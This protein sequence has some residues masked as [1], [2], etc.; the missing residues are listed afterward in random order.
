MKLI[1][2]FSGAGGLS[3]GL[4]R[5]GYEVKAC[6]EINR[7]AMNTY[8][9][10]DPGAVKFNED[11]RGID[12]TQFRGKVD[13]VS[14]GP[15]CQPFSIGGLRKASSD[16]R[17]MIPEFVRCLEEVQ[18]EAFIME[19]VPGLLLKATRP[20]FDWAL[21]QL[22]STGYVLNWA[23]LNAADYGVPQKR[24]R[25]FVLGSR[26]SH[27][28][29]P[30]PTHG[31]G[32]GVPHVSA[33]EV[34]GPDPIGEAPNCP[35]RYARAPDLRPSPYAGHV[36]NG[37][38][39]P[40]DPRGPCHTILA[41]SGGYKTHWIDTL[42]VAA[43]YHAHLK[44]GGQ[45]RDGMVQGARRLSVE[46]CAIIQA[47]P[48]DMEFAGARSAQYK[49]VGDAVPPDLAFVIGRSVYFQLHGRSSQINLV[50][51]SAEVT[52]LQGELALI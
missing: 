1:D 18:P 46:E 4:K 26:R 39:R 27:L 24:R 22:A 47:F 48:R 40:L 32:V 7:D 14:G 52:S 35:V 50:D 51:V 20:Y 12:F 28:R 49:Q 33:L 34:L 44:S 6:V 16:S 3:L 5:A 2:L 15:P 29:F 19:N 17:D 10:H 11:V 13:V 23:V 30:A 36:Y 25:L 37:G 41:S 8:S 31:T 42:G 38:G 9:L 21:A 45:P 43:E